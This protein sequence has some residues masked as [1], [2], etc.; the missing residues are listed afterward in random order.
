MK[1]LLCSSS[2]RRIELLKTIFNEFEIV[3]PNFDESKTPLSLGRNYALI[4]AKNKLFSCK[5]LAKP[6]YLLIS[7]DTIV[8]INNE[9]IGK[10]KDKSDAFNILKKLNNKTHEVL[11]GY[12]FLFN[13]QY[14]ENLISTKVT[15]NNLTDA[16]INDYIE[17]FNILDKAGAYAIQDNEKSHLIK[18]INGSYNN[19]VG[20]PI[21]DIKKDLIRLKLIK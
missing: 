8:F 17:K 10:P 4:Q 18:E 9:I 5:N 13:D 16:E 14:H 19:V 1:I 21:E 15:F 12:C 20:F 7:C 3:K 2:P 6:N 11:S